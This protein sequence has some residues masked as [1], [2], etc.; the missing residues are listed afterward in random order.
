AADPDNA[1][2][3]AL[4]EQPPGRVLELPIFERG[5]GQFGSVHQ[6]YTLQAPR[7]RPTGYSLAPEEVF[8]F[9]ARFNRLECGAWLPGDREELERLG[10]RYLVWHR[11]LYQQSRTPGAWFG[12]EGLTRGGLGPVAGSPVVLLFVPGE[13]AASPPSA[14]EPDRAQP[15]LCDGWRDGVLVQEEGALWLYGSGRAELVFEAPAPTAA[16]V[17]ADGELVAEHIVLGPATVTVTADL[18]GSGWHAFVVRGRP[19]LR[20]VEASLP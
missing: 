4:R 19:G 14:L 16:A 8:A 18:S 10:I 7:E 11:G 5:E 13:D 6:Y 17:F 9:T 20:L 3:A 1:A 15:F 12:W 2:Y